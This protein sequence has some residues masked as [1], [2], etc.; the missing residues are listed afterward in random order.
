MFSEGNEVE[1]KV[2]KKWV[3]LLVLI[4]HILTV[5]IDPVMAFPDEGNF[6]PCVKKSVA[7]VNKSSNSFY[8][9]REGDT[10]WAISRDL[11]V[12]LGLLMSANG[13][14]GGTILKIGQNIIIPGSGTN[15]YLLKKGDTMWSIAAAYGISV[16]ELQGLNQTKNPNQLKIGDRIIIPAGKQRLATI[17]QESSRGFHIGRSFYAWPLL[18]TI[19]SYYGWRKSGFHH[20]LDIAGKTNTPIRASAPGKVLFAGYKEVYGRTV[21]IDHANGEQTLYAH[22]SKTLV[23]PGQKVERGETIAR[24]GSSGRATG[25]HLHFEI[26]KGEQIFNPLEF[27]R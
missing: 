22:A 2:D 27:L 24:V 21:I 25:P 19:T 26:R 7:A 23:K 11:N 12:D 3:V 16:K 20:G 15:Y 8:K 18:G 6:L 17:T 4:T 14:N 1:N 9:V 5:S 13:Y 10:L